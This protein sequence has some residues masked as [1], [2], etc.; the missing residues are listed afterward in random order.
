MTGKQT[1]SQVALSEFDSDDPTLNL[2]R[3]RTKIKTELAHV[4][5]IIENINPVSSHMHSGYNSYGANSG[6]FTSSGSKRTSAKK[7]KE[8]WGINIQQVPRDKE[9]RGCFV[10]SEGYKFLIADYSQIELRLAAELIG[11]PQLIVT[12]KQPRNSLSRGTC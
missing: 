8:Y 1:L 10:P 5:K 12:G 9:F 7:A 4:D 2:L 3:K 11:I 6:R